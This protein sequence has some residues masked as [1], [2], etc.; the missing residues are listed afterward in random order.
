[1]PRE[2]LVEHWPEANDAPAQI[3]GRDLER[4]DGIVGRRFGRRSAGNRRVVHR[5]LA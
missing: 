2:D 3:E 5:A 4:Q 1:M